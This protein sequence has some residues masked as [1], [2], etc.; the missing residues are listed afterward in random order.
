MTQNYSVKYC[1]A[2]GAGIRAGSTFCGLCGTRLPVEQPGLVTPTPAASSGPRA[3]GVPAARGKAPLLVGALMAV[4]LA[5]VVGITS[6][7]ALIRPDVD[8]ARAMPRE[9][10]GYAAVSLGADPL[11]LYASAKASQK[12]A[13]KGDP[14]WLTELLADSREDGVNLEADILPWVG[15]KAAVGAYSPTASDGPEGVYPQDTET[16]FVLSVKNEKAARAGLRKMLAGRQGGDEDGLEETT[17]KKTSITSA[18]Y[19]TTAFAVTDGMAILG[20]SEETV[21]AAVDSLRGDRPNLTESAG[22][23]RVLKNLPD[24]RTA[25]FYLDAKPWLSRAGDR[26]ELARLKAPGLPTEGL[27]GG[28]LSPMK[29]GNRIDFYGYAPD[30]PYGIDSKD[31]DAAGERLAKLA[32]GDS[33]L[34][35]AGEDLSAWW[36]RTRENMEETLGGIGAGDTLL[37]MEQEA[38][39]DLEKDLFGPYTGEYGVAMAKPQPGQPAG[40]GFALLLETPDRDMARQS[41]ERVRARLEEDQPVFRNTEIAGKEAF[42]LDNGSAESPSAGYVLDDGH[43]AVGSEPML[44]RVIEHKDTLAEA[45]LYQN[46]V[47]QLEH[48]DDALLYVDVRGAL[49]TIYRD[50]P[51]ERERMLAKAKANPVTAYMS[52]LR[53]VVIA[54][55]VRGDESWGSMLLINGNKEAK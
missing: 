38:G 34:F 22:Y 5:L 10:V 3:N 9:T 16:L 49:D 14:G 6:I 47:G 26:A 42:L 30:N 12:L 27:L 32:P 39:V 51:E 28:S 24:A 35:Y 19:G 17:Y 11:T 13:G 31:D 50:R 40:T 44:R 25:W 8:P 41:L 23:K 7:R 1:P 48:R 36:K 52:R 18:K 20:R 46:A 53:A 4:L 29:G 54:T 37:R 45:P 2:C 55:D 15:R 21:Q 43:L 33:Y